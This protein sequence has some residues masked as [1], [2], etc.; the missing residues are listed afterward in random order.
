MRQRLEN[1]CYLAKAIRAQTSRADQNLAAGI[2]G[3]LDRLSYIRADRIECGQ[4][5]KSVGGAGRSFHLDRL[6]F[7]FGHVGRLPGDRRTQCGG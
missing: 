7:H 3:N 4:N 1:R 6:A 2:V 5:V